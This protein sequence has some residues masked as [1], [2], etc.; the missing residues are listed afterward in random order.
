MLSLEGTSGA[1][2]PDG[3][4]LES[5]TLTDL[6]R[7]CLT[8]PCAIQAGQIVT[9]TSPVELFKGTEYWL[10][11]SAFSDS[12]NGWGNNVT[13]AHGYAF[14]S[15]TTPNFV[16]RTG[17]SPAFAVLGTP[18]PEPAALGLMVLG[19]LVGAGAGFVRCK[20]TN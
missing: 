12:T 5:F 2:L 7:N 9:S 4:P 15:S 19:L 20:R 13:G 1:G 8:F 3:K 6:P 11:A 17:T 10:V 18:V 16:F 14:R